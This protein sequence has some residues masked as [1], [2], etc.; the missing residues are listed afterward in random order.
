MKKQKERLKE[1]KEKITED[2]KY[3]LYER[4]LKRKSNI[5]QLYKEISE[6]YH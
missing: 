2:E 6:N 3:F 4:K 1:N 5:E